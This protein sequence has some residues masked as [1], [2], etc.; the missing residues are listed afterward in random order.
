MRPGASASGGVDAERWRQRGRGVDSRCAR[1][2]LG[3]RHV[4]HR[5]QLA[6]FAVHLEDDFFRFQVGDGLAV[7]RDGQ[8]IDANGF[9]PGAQRAPGSLLLS[10]QPQAGDAQ[11][12]DEQ[13]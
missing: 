11:Q 1:G 13:G 9:A 10:G 12:H 8:K 5:L 7:S 6:G 2:G 3:D 4:F